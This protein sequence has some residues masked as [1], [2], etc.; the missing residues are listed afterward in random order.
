MHAC[1]VHLHVSSLDI[2]ILR[3]ANVLF[4]LWLQ[5]FAIFAFATTGGY[6]GSSSV[7]VQCGA[8][9]SQEITVKFGYPFRYVSPGGLRAI[10]RKIHG[11]RKV[12]AG[13]IFDS[14]V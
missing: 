2:L 10:S 9:P 5:V 1:V 11:R 7:N 3:P 4:G 13:G 8:S 12:F 6:S 14:G